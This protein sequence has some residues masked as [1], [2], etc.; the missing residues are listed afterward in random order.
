MRVPAE[1]FGLFGL[2]SK[3]SSSAALPSGGLAPVVRLFRLVCR[4]A[5][6]E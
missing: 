6:C 4:F 1:K 3:W 5:L 2:Q